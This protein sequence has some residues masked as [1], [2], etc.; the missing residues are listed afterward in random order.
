MSRALRYIRQYEENLEAF[1]K[2]S[3]CPH[4]TVNA[5]LGSFCAQ[6]QKEGFRVSA[7]A[8]TQQESPVAD[9]DFVAILSKPSGKR[10]QRLQ[11]MRLGRGNPRGCPHR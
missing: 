1:G 5:V 10:L 6:A 11:G 4:A 7:R 3:F 2:A 9:I 8:D